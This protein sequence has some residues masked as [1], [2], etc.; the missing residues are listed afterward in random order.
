MIKQM[1]KAQI[2]WAPSIATAQAIDDEIRR[3]RAFFF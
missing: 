3:L 2:F 1:T